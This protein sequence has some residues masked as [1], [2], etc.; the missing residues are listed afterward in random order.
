M[1]K[2]FTQEN[3]LKKAN[4]I[5]NNIY[6]YSE[7]IYICSSVKVIIICKIHGKFYKTPNHH[8]NGQ[9]CP[10]C[11]KITSGKN[12]TLTTKDVIEEFILIHNNFYDY[13]EVEYISVN[14]HIKIICPIHG[15]F[16]QTPHLHKCGK[17]CPKCGKLKNS[18]S[19]RLTLEEFNVKAND[20]HGDKF[21]YS[22]VIYKNHA[23]K[24]TIICLLH[25]EFNQT[26]NNHLSGQGCPKCIN[27][28]SKQEIDWLNQLQIPQEYRQSYINNKKYFVDALDPITNI[29]YEFYGDYWHG[30]PKK[31]DS[32]DFNKFVNKTFGELY[33][34]TINRENILIEAGY[35]IISIWE[36]DWKIYNKTVLNVKEI[37]LPRGK[38]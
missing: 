8:L 6:D 26:P 5:Y 20:I 30:N 24:I 1:D 19:I 2:A 10:L 27:R 9:G 16:L 29:V 25:G 17:G 31:F 28:I 21:D 34:Q 32:N 36:Q 33:S 37:L 38:T 35:K 23:T 15:L 3:F 4:A 22:K 12:R 11:S 13:H 18:E 7:T 14:K